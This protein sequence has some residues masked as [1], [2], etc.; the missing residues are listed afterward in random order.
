MKK[1]LILTSERTGTGHKSSANAIEKKLNNLGYETKQVDSFI[2]M[3]KIGKIL[4]NL[5]IPIT[6]RAPLLYY[7]PFLLT[8]MFPDVMHFLIYLLSNKRFKK[9]FLDYKPDLIITVHCMFTK[10]VS[11]LLKKQ[12]LTIPFYINVIDLIKPPKVWLDKRA[13]A[14]FVPT[15][16]VKEYYIKKGIDS[17]KVFVSGFPIR[18]DIIKRTTPK[19]INDK[20]NILIVNPSINLNKSIKYIKE[21]SKLDNVAITVV[22]GRDE[23]LYNKLIKNQKSGNISNNIKIYGFINN[24]NE[25]LN[26]SHIILTKAGPNMILEA[27]KSATP[28]II[29]GHI[30]G[31]ENEN[32]RFV[33]DNNYGF[34]CE[35]PNYIYIK[36]N[37]FIKSN[38]L[39]QYLNN[40]LNSKCTD[41]SD[42]IANY[43]KDN[44]K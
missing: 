10:S 34:K 1:V 19:E 26:N 22:C 25:V 33:E 32:Y 12:K 8:Q 5:Y 13:D 11:Y 9:I 20:I 21:V 38:K 24:I 18:D 42:F 28:I 36:L 41:G 44:L 3:G 6:T 14:L 39:D 4:E 30:L 27:V 17:K 31:Q 37:N 35:N 7:I 29:T 2:T 15:N 16:E 43:I 40:V 23:R